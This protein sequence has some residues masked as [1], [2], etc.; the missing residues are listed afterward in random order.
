MVIRTVYNTQRFVFITNKLFSDSKM[1]TNIVYT[2]IYTNMHAYL[3]SVV[4]KILYIIKLS[5]KMVLHSFY[6][7]LIFAQ[8]LNILRIVFATHFLCLFFHLLLFFCC[9]LYV[10]IK[11]NITVVFLVVVVYMIQ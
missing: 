3:C 10:P 4:F 2:Y 7:F 6:F 1:N 9:S 5:T 11:I 8:T